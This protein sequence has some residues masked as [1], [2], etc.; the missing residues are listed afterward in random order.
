MNTRVS[1]TTEAGL[2]QREKLE[3]LEL[4]PRELHIAKLL[5]WG[6]IQK[7]IADML[8][9]SHLTVSSH[10]KNIYH[11]LSIHKETDL[12]R[13]Y[14]FKEYSIN[15]NPFKKV[16]AVMFLVLSC[17]MALQEQNSVRIFRSTPIRTAARV[18]RPARVKRYRNV[19]EFQLSPA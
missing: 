9:I 14:L 15:D 16:L 13:W 6:Y 8:N 1:A 18:A 12:T 11:K 19:F 3:C 4:S 17:T 7:E 2:F 10:M 5:T